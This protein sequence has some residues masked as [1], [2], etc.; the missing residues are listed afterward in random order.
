MNARKA[1]AIR[2][3]VLKIIEAFPGEIA[4]EGYVKGNTTGMIMCRPKGPR[5]IEKAVKKGRV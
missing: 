3:R 1:K 2:R 5:W 4:R